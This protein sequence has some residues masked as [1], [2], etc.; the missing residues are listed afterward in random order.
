MSD[1]KPDLYSI[2][3]PLIDDF[4]ES[5]VN[6]FVKDIVNRAQQSL[7][8]QQA[9][10]VG[11]WL[12]NLDVYTAVKSVESLLNS[13]ADV[14][15]LEVAQQQNW[16]VHFDHLAIRCKPSRSQHILL[17]KKARPHLANSNS[18]QLDGSQAHYQTKVR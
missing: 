11:S 18:W 16:I 14:A 17:Q 8:D 9:N 12:A 6:Q 3:G 5:S 4:P 2:R 7:T 10:L 1:N 15:L 13:R